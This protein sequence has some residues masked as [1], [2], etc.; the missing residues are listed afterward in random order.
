VQLESSPDKLVR[1][2]VIE[3]LKESLQDTPNRSFKGDQQMY[4]DVRYKL[5]IDPSEDESLPR[6]LLMYKILDPKKTRIFTCSDF[7]EDSQ[8]QKACLCNMHV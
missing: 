8:L 7:P 3:I 4:N 2:N 6:L 5:I 1:R